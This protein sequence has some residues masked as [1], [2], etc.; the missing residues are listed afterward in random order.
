M[1]EDEDRC[2]RM[3]SK[4]ATTRPQWR[5]SREGPGVAPSRLKRS[6]DS[7]TIHRN[8]RNQLL[9][10][11]RGKNLPGFSIFGVVYIWVTQLKSVKPRRLESACLIL[12]LGSLWIAFV[13]NRT[14]TGKTLAR[15]FAS[16]SGVLLKFFRFFLLTLCFSSLL[17][18]KFRPPPP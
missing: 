12:I 13:S 18:N 11:G 8:I 7:E 5:G 2:G 15:L 16:K 4:E 6:N 3:S 1:T 10:L 14:Q 17:R 9:V